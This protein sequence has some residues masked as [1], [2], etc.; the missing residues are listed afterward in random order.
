MRTLISF[1]TIS[2]DGFF[3]DKNGD[4]R[5]AHLGGEDP[6]FAA[7]VGQNASSGGQLL[8]GRVTYELM[9]SYWPTQNAL[10]DNPV[11]AKGMNAMPKIVFSR[12]LEKTAWEN[13]R[14]IKSDLADAVRTLK[15]EPGPG[16]AILGSGTIIS[17]LAQS[18][19]IDE[20]QFV[21]NPIILGEGRTQFAGV[22]DK[23]NLKL[24]TSRTFRNGKVYLSYKPA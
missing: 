7:F 2:T 16:M 3:T 22:K 11:V 6:E 10:R 20:F 14:L 21:V 8:F 23:L 13:T 12:T 4:S 18:G 17:Q 19:L 15:S 5:W 9:A 1:N 24:L